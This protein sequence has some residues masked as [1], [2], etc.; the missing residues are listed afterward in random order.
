MDLLVEHALVE[1]MQHV[2]RPLRRVVGVDRLGDQRL[3]VVD[4]RV[5]RDL[6]QERLLRGEVAVR[7]GARHE[8]GLRGLGHGRG[9]A[10]VHQRDGGVDDRLAGALLLVDPASAGAGGRGGLTRDCHAV[11][12]L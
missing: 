1:P 3:E 2:E 5:Q 4:V 8:G 12:V 7:R 6:E 11:M 10:L 9:A